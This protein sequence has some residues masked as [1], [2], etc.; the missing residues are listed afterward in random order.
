VNRC[1]RGSAVRSITAW[2]FAPP[3]A[4]ALAVQVLP[5]KGILTHRFK[6]IRMLSPAEA[7]HAGQPVPESAFGAGATR[8]IAENHG[9]AA[10]APLSR[11]SRGPVGGRRPCMP[12]TLL[13]GCSWKGPVPLLLAG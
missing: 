1:F 2:D 6:F 11:S 12:P 8:G 13:A 5:P 4:F 3:A 7:T 10:R 9:R